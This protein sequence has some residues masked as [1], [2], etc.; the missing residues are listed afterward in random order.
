MCLCGVELLR[1]RLSSGSESE[2]K[3]GANN[4]RKLPPLASGHPIRKMKAHHRHPK[5]EW[6][7]G[8]MFSNLVYLLAGFL[9]FSCGQY[10]CALFQ[11]GAAVA[12]SMFHRSKETK[13]LAVDAL[14]SST[15][16][17]VWIFVAMHTLKNEW[18]GLLA[19]KLS[20]GLLCCFT[21]L[22]CGLPGGARYEVWHQRWHYVSGMTTMTTTL[23]LMFYVPEFDLI[24]H[25][26]LQDYLLVAAWFA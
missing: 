24:L 9:S 1:S 25:E 13:Y 23:F 2:A 6:H 22:Y 7:D 4:L 19:I 5:R 15:L 11:C 12:S 14:I 18:Y 26:L 20:Q 10:F 21:W 17:V 16:A 8:L 3:C